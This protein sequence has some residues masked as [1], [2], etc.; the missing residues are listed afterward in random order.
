MWIGGTIKSWDV[1]AGSGLITPDDGSPDFSCHIGQLVGAEYEAPGWG[2]PVGT[3]VEFKA[4]SCGL[5]SVIAEAEEWPEPRPPED[6]PRWW[7]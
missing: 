6:R 7:N 5:I 1:D 2:P 4:T 3:R